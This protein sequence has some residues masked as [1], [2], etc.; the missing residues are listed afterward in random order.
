MEAVPIELRDLI[1]EGAEGNPFYVEELIKMLIEDEVIIYGDQHWLVEMDRLARVHVPPTL[2]GV[3]QARLDSLPP[4]EKI[5]L[6]LKPAAASGAGRPDIEPALRPFYRHRR[7]PLCR[8]CRRIWI[9]E[10]GPH[11]NGDS[12]FWRRVCDRNADRIWLRSAIPCCTRGRYS[13]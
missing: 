13:A 3:L 5:L 2:T 4:D 10:S 7:L 8:S 11:D 12:L 6:Q 1:V 9:R